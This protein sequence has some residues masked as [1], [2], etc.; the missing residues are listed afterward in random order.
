MYETECCMCKMVGV[1]LGSKKAHR[2]TKGKTQERE[3]ERERERERERVS[4]REGG[5][6]DH[7]G[8]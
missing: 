7:C 2:E 3:K 8:C 5:G 6:G 4:E 1:S